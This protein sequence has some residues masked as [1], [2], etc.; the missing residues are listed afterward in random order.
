MSGDIDAR[1][2][3]ALLRTETMAADMAEM[4]GDMRRMAEALTTLA[5]VEERQSR[6]RADIGRAFNLLDGHEGRIGTLEKAQ[7]MQQ[8]TTKIIDKVIWVVISTVLTA[9]VT[10]VVVNR[11]VDSHKGDV[12][13]LSMPAK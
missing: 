8:Q 6:D 2:V 1:V 5:V 10:T 9:V 3:A 12:P 4:K 13:Q 7:P 11:S